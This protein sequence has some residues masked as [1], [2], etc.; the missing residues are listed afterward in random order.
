MPHSGADGGRTFHVVCA[1]GCKAVTIVRP[2]PDA[3]GRERAVM[4]A[5]FARSSA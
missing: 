1:G 3:P 2:D 4:R 5:E